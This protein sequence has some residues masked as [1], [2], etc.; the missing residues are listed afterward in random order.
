MRLHLRRAVR[1]VAPLLLLVALGVP[2][3][4]TRAAAPTL[5]LAPPAGQAG[6]RVAA[7]G[8]GFPPGAEGQLVWVPSGEVLAAFRTDR[9][10]RFRA[11]FA[12]PAA[13]AGAAEVAAQVGDTVAEATFTVVAP[14]DA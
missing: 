3:A 13:E 1:A 5:S 7:R 4:G 14:T 2:S 12:A 8:A 10:G 9:A 6:T 11:R